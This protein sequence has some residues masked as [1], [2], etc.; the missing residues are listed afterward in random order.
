MGTVL[1]RTIELNIFGLDN[2]LIEKMKEIG[3]SKGF[4]VINQVGRL[5]FASD[6]EFDYRVSKFRSLVTELRVV[7]KEYGINYYDLLDL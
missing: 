1:V 2:E 5:I 6:S 4:D 3:E 7:C